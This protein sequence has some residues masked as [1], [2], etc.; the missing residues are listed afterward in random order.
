[1]IAM[2]ND[3]SLPEKFE[4]KKSEDMM[5]KFIKTCS[6]CRIACKRIENNFCLYIN[7]NFFGSP[8]IQKWIETRPNTWSSGDVVF[9]QEIRIPYDSDEKSVFVSIESE[10]K[11]SE[12]TINIDG[13]SVKNMSNAGH[14][15]DHLK[16][17]PIWN[18]YPFKSWKPD[19]DADEKLLPVAKLSD[20]VWLM[21]IARSKYKEARKKCIPKG[22]IDPAPPGIM[23]FFHVPEN[24]KERD[25][26]WNKFTE[27]LRPYPGGGDKEAI[28]IEIFTKISSVNGFIPLTSR[29]CKKTARPIVEFPYKFKFYLA[30]DKETGAFEVYN[31][32]KVHQGEWNFFGRK[33]TNK[34]AK[35]TRDICK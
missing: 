4:G 17:F 20:Y 21:F 16:C 28:I 27:T 14:I 12:P 1:M 34:P 3:N 19:F 7:D 26:Y 32:K 13:N 11:W 35:P 15:Y 31:K 6:L 22:G 24:N 25:F 23:D 29:I 18:D 30:P 8:F 2:F 33:N 10:Q 5:K 9:L